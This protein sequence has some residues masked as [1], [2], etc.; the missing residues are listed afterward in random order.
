MSGKER[1]EQEATSLRETL[2]EQRYFW[3][4]RCTYYLRLSFL[5]YLPFGTLRT[6]QLNI[7]R[8]HID[9]LDSALSNAQSTVLRLEEEVRQKEVYVDRV[10]S[11]TK[12]LEQLQVASE[13]REGMEKKLRQ[14]LGKT[15][16]SLSCLSDWITCHLSTRGGAWAAEE[17]TGPW[18]QR[19]RGRAA[20]CSPDG[21][22]GG[23][24]LPSDDD[25]L[26]EDDGM[27]D[28]DV[29]WSSSLARWPSRRWV[30][31][32][33]SKFPPQN[34]INISP[35]I[36]RLESERT[37]WEQRYLEESAMRQVAIDAASMPK[38]AKIAILEKTGADAE[39]KLSDAR[40][41][42]LKMQA[43][44]QQSQRK[45][46][47]MDLKLRSLEST[48][49]EKNSMIKVL[50]K[51]AS[52]S[53]MNVLSIPVHDSL[54]NSTIL[55]SKQLSTTVDNFPNPPILHSKQLSQST[56]TTSSSHSLPHH[57]S[58]H[59]A[60]QLSTPA[61]LSLAPG[62]PTR[63]PASSDFFDGI[64]S[65]M[66]STARGPL[67]KLSLH[68][69]GEERRVRSGSPGVRHRSATPQELRELLE[70]RAGT[71]TS[72]TAASLAARTTA[73]RDSAPAGGEPGPASPN[74]TW[75]VKICVLCHLLNSFLQVD[76]HKRAVHIISQPALWRNDAKNVFCADEGGDVPVGSAQMSNV[77]S[78]DLL[79]SEPC[80]QRGSTW[81]R[82]QQ[83]R[84]GA[85][86]RRRWVRRRGGGKT[87]WTSPTWAWTPPSPS[88]TTWA[89]TRPS[90]TGAVCW[91]RWRTRRRAGQRA[92][93]ESRSRSR[94]PSCQRVGVQSSEWSEAHSALSNHQSDVGHQQQTVRHNILKLLLRFLLRFSLDFQLLM[95]AILDLLRTNHNSATS[96]KQVS[97]F[98]NFI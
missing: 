75:V 20:A 59:H 10:K 5:H 21:R 98:R 78:T 3:Q 70:R 32:C 92:T 53:E 83:G 97:D 41:E 77:T 90:W 35:Q 60:P 6:L 79:F 2:Q 49:A 67:T 43:D 16:Q 25:L 71:P 84:M 13:K 33:C 76:Q 14:K 29:E 39:K 91:R 22:A 88:W 12:S 50:Q 65:S 15:R 8:A 18:A 80:R 82:P 30:K 55:H 89:S 27:I 47:D 69:R 36:I 74:R 73:R 40:T 66:S 26:D 17:G 93:G 96:L 37:Q 61:P 58:P 57:S 11:M 95:F 94:S 7:P 44:M 31:L 56:L 85:T 48:V 51:K 42:K 45:V 72:L 1:Q 86:I 62:S 52:E 64:T 54:S 34:L 24:N 87:G 68:Q 23:E 46:N 28:E 19:R 38:D 9:V 81:Q 63:L 4:K